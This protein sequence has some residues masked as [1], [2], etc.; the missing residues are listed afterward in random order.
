[1]KENEQ[2][3]VETASRVNPKVILFNIKKA[4]KRCKEEAAQ[5][6]ASKITNAS[7]QTIKQLPTL[8]C[9][10]R[11]VTYIRKSDEHLPELPKTRKI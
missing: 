5:S 6:V 10:R 11:S 4:A 9:M 1:M 2:N 8:K 7:P 3:H